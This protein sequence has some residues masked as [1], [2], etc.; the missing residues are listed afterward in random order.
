MI[1]SKELS[2]LALVDQ[3]SGGRV[4]LTYGR[5][6]VVREISSLMALNIIF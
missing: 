6:V 1:F 2:D 3:L 4:D 5:Q